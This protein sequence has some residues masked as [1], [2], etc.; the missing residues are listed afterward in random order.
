[1]SFDFDATYSLRHERISDSTYVCPPFLRQFDGVNLIESG[2]HQYPENIEANADDISFSVVTQGSGGTAEKTEITVPSTGAI[3]LTDFWSPASF[4]YI[5][6][7]TDTQW[8]INVNISDSASSYSG[9]GKQITI[10]VSEHSTPN[11][12]ADEFVTAFNLS[13]EF[14]A[15]IKPGTTNVV[16]VENTANGVATDASGAL[17]EG[18]LDDGTYGY[19]AIYV[20]HDRNGNVH[21]SAPSAPISIALSG[22]A[23]DQFVS[24]KVPSLQLT[25]KQGDFGDPIIELYRTTANGTI[26]YKVLNVNTSEEHV[27]VPNDTTREWLILRDQSVDDTELISNEILYTTGGIVENIGPPA[28]KHLTFLKDVAMIAGIPGKPNKVWFSKRKVDGLGLSFYDGFTIDASSHGGKIKGLAS[29][30]EKWFIGNETSMLWT[31]GNGFDDLGSGQGF[32]EPQFVSKNIGIDTD[33]IGYIPD[34]FIFKSHKG[35]YLASRSLQLSYI[36]AQVE[37]FNSLTTQNAITLKGNHQIRFPHSDG[38][39]LVYDY[40]FKQWSTFT[41]LNAVDAHVR[42]GIYELLRSNG[43]SWTETTAYQDPSATQIVFKFETGWIQMNQI[44]GFQRLWQLA[45]LGEFKAD[46][47]YVVETKYDHVD[48]LVD[49]YEYEPAA[50][51]KQFEIHMKKQKCEAIKFS[52]E[53]FALSSAFSDVQVDALT[54]TVGLKKG[55]VKLGASRAAYNSSP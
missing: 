28:C 3:K 16:V 20:W 47:R 42:E 27:F 31:V 5:Y 44:Q 34:G 2:F 29:I 46:Y 53:D 40:F 33:V 38:A 48:T 12:V 37:D 55:F 7:S 11:E 49:T 13:T 6:D 45:V 19:R 14:T 41:G 8:T 21:R 26:Y 54:A 52:F 9:A 17:G 22:G 43:L 4:F 24:I 30:D 35:F 51:D 15:S 25:D 1:V 18:V 50:N 32:I 39:T 23:A 36:G 10:R